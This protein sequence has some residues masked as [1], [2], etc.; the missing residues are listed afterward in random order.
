MLP[1]GAVA[2]HAPRL[3]EQHEREQTGHLAI[4]REHAVDHARD[5]DRLLGQVGPLEVR[6]R[7]GCVPLVED[8]V[9]HVEDHAQPT[10]LL[11][12]R[13]HLSPNPLIPAAAVAPKHATPPH[14]TCGFHGDPGSRGPT[15]AVL[16]DA[17]YEC[18]PSG[19]RRRTTIW[20]TWAPIRSA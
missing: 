3:R 17:L 11:R 4:G 14:E 8:E 6:A 2:R 18:A 13:R 15:S 9:Q 1:S 12:C 10:G 20:R 5:A 16:S 19:P 7:R